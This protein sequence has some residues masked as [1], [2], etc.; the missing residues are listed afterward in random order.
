MNYR[1]SQTAGLSA[2][3]IRDSYSDLAIQVAEA[4]TRKPTRRPR[5]TCRR[6]GEHR[7]SNLRGHCDDCE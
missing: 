6:C 7:D 5:F 4:E 1:D 2:A 3:T